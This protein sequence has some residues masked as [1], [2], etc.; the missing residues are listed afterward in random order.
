MTDEEL[1]KFLR[2]STSACF[3]K[4][5]AYRIEALIAE[6][7]EALEWLSANQ[8]YIADAVFAFE[9]LA[10]LISEMKKEARTAQKREHYKMH[11]LSEVLGEIRKV[12]KGESHE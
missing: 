12:V 9:A 2:T 11:V 6:R 4:T 1:I 7:D 8:G 3:N 5:A 10:E